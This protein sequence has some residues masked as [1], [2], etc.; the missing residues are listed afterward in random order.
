MPYLQANEKGEII[1]YRETGGES[2]SAY[3]AAGERLVWSEI[4]YPKE[5]HWINSFDEVVERP[6]MPLSVSGMVIA[7]IPEGATLKLGEQE[8]IVNDGEADIDGYHGSVK[9]SCWPYL[10]EEVKI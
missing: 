5:T 2:L 1:A 6:S 10:D 8:F 4:G 7:G 3:L 9:L